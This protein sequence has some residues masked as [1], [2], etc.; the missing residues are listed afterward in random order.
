MRDDLK[1]GCAISVVV[2]MFGI[3]VILVSGFIKSCINGEGRDNVVKVVGGY[4]IIQLEDGH[5]YMKV[6]RCS[7]N[8]YVEC[9]KCN[10]K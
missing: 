1:E 8:H 10:K 4:E 7:I 5:W 6:D 2:I 3:L 9:P